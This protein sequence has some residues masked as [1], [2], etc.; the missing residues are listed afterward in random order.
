MKKKTTKIKTEFTV[1]WRM[2]KGGDV[3]SHRHA[4]I[5]EAFAHAK[6]LHSYGFY[7]WFDIEQTVYEPERMY[8]NMNTI[9][10]YD[11]GKKTVGK[12]ESRFNRIVTK[13]YYFN[14]QYKRYNTEC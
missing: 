5:K 14:N 9:W 2:G 3:N 4:T 11:N 7:V 8:T 10:L 1:V 12:M 13:Q 6:R